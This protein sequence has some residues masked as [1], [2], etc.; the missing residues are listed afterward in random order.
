[1]NLRAGGEPSGAERLTMLEVEGMKRRRMAPRALAQCSGCGVRA[2]HGPFQDLTH[3][4]TY[5]KYSR[6][7]IKTSIKCKLGGK[8]SR[9]VKMDGF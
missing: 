4:Q 8:L 3:H 5:R 6:F 9:G 1:M 2:R 7:S